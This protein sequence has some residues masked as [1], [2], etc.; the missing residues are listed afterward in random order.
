MRARPAVVVFLLG[1]IALAMA[2][3]VALR[4]ELIRRL[5]RAESAHERYARALEESGLGTSALAADWL[6]AATA[7]RQSPAAIETPFARDITIDAAKPL[8]AGFALSLRRGQKLDVHVTVTGAA[9]ARVFL[10]LFGAAAPAANRPI[11]S[12]PENGADLA[13]EVRE[14]GAYVLRVQPE[15]LRA[16]RMRVTVKTGPSL[17]FPVAGGTARSL[18]SV[19]GDERDAGRRRHEG[20]DIFAARGTPVVAASSGVVTSVGEN[21]LGGRVVWVLDVSRGLTQYYAHLQD[22]AVRPGQF[23]AAGDTLGTVGNT[24]NARTTPPHLHFGIYAPGQGALD[25]APFIRPSVPVD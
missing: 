16:G 5:M 14:T 23:V 24:G 18:Q 7:A 1:T 25:P 15:L 11:V 9:P 8:A 12:A 13:H 22:Q 6:A 10:D 2:V 19:F 4:P 3:L 20:V 17:A 21:R